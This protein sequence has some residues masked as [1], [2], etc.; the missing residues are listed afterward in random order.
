L[1]PVAAM[2]TPSPIMTRP[3]APPISASRRGDPPG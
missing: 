1:R 3:P 2:L